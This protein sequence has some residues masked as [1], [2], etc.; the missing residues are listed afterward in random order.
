MR[1]EVSCEYKA[2]YFISDDRSAEI[3]YNRRELSIFLSAYEKAQK[4]IGQFFKLLYFCFCLCSVES[5]FL[6]GRN[7]W[8]MHIYGNSRFIM[9][10]SQTGPL[11]RSW[12]QVLRD[13]GYASVSVGKTHMIHAGS[14]HI[15]VPLSKTFGKR[16]GWDHF[17]VEK[18]PEPESTYYDI[19]VASRACYALERLQGDGPFALF[20]GFHA[21]HEPYVL[22]EK[23]WNY[24]RPDDVVLPVNR[25]KD[26]FRT[27][28]ESY[29]RRINHFQSM[30]GDGIYNDEDIRT[31]IAGYYSALKM[32]DDCIG[33]IYEKMEELNLLENTIVVFTSDHG[34]MLGEHYLFNKNATSYE[35][36]IHIPFM[37]RFPDGW[38]AGKEFSQ[39]GCAIDF[40]P[41]LMDLLG[42]DPDLP[43]PG[44]SLLPCMKDGK[45]VRQDRLIW[46]ARGSLTLLSPHAKLM[47]CPEDQDGELY[48]LVKDPQEMHNLWNQ[49]EGKALQDE[50]IQRMLHQRLWN[51]MRAS[52]FTAREQ[53]LHRE[54]K[55]S[56]EP[57]VV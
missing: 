8:D 47:Y 20:V 31:G 2:Q 13:E 30:F 9:D 15:P 37:I 44:V 29:R 51:D 48:D 36:E 45:E 26:E 55:A 18:S 49:P 3:R 27:K 46:H 19:H 25:S 41:T 12:M 11:E 39:R 16:D 43:L 21:P 5:M 40:F 4:R 34:E 7:A 54:I 57:E 17:H 38:N 24:C 33:T 23:Y 6:M 50:M 53:L 42:L 35:G 52:R 22:P 10:G 32:V 1:G 28:S 14:Y 56:M